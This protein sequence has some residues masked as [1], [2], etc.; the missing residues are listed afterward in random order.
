MQV[1]LEIHGDPLTS[2]NDAHWPIT[3]DRRV[4]GMVTSAVYSPRLEKNIALA[5]VGKDY[6]ELGT[7]L[8]IKSSSGNLKGEVVPKPFYDPNK[9][10]TTG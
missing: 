7:H 3:R 4:I 1:G 6:A 8:A 2:P 5:M 10:I 9:N